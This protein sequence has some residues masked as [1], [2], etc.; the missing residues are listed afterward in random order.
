MRKYFTVGLT[1]V[2]QQARIESFLSTTCAVLEAPQGAAGRREL[3]VPS[4]RRDGHRRERL[5]AIDCTKS[6]NWGRSGM[7]GS[8]AGLLEGVTFDL[9][10]PGF[11]WLHVNSEPLSGYS[12]DS[13]HKAVTGGLSQL[14]QNSATTTWEGS[15]TP[16]LG[17]E[18]CSGSA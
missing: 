10:P 11:L 2:C 18:V 7:V 14:S 8:T 13:A 16:R 4:L 5:C 3:L 6:I 1:S 12:R 15:L 9:W 17:E